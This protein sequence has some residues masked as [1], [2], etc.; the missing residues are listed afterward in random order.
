MAVID[1]V[2]RGR[3]LMHRNGREVW[4]GCAAKSSM[5]IPSAA[6]VSLSSDSLSSA[7]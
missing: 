6:Y 1:L 3:R 2:G 4:V 7:S 5:N